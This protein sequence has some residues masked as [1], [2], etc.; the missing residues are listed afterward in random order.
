[1]PTLYKEVERVLERAMKLFYKWRS[2]FVVMVIV[3]TLAVGLTQ[4]QAAD[5]E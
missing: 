4:T 1:M 3:T 5:A 2:S